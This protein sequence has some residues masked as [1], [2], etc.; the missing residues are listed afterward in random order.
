[1]VPIA[2]DLLNICLENVS[3]NIGAMLKMKRTERSSHYSWIKT[4]THYMWRSLA[5]LSESPSVAVSVMDH[6]KS[7]LMF[8]S[9]PWVFQDHDP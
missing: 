5:A 2:L 6:V 8:L 3:H 7:K 1:M 4:I 9:L